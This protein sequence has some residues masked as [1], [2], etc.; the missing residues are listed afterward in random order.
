MCLICFS[1]NALL[2]FI[3]S[4]E[5]SFLIPQ[6]SKE[7]KNKKQFNYGKA[8]RTKSLA[9]Y[10]PVYLYRPIWFFFVQSISYPLLVFFPFQF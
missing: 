3:V 6:I 5:P 10:T 9:S 1:F 7:L 4:A 2:P 8:Q